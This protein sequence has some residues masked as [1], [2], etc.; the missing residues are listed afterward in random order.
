MKIFFEKVYLHLKNIKSLFFTVL[1]AVHSFLSLIS[2]ISYN[3]VNL[4]FYTTVLEYSLIIIPLSSVLW[5]LFIFR[6]SIEGKGNELLYMGKNK[7]KFLDGFIPFLL[8][9]LTIIFQFVIYQNIESA[10]KLELIRLFIISFFFFCLTYFIVFLSKSIALTLMCL[11]GYTII[12]ILI[13]GRDSV[14]G[15]MFYFNVQPYGKSLFIIQSI[16]MIILSFI[17]LFAALI[18][19]KTNRKFN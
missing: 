8:F 1:I 12:N 4:D 19:N 13:D 6:E 11:I 18:L 9:Y 14:V 2:I 16:P 3:S 10:F 5:S 17:L 7:I 15:F